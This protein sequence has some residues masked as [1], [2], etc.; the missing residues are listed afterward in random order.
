[1]PRATFLMR[2]FAPA[3]TIGKLARCVGMA[4]STL[5]KGFKCVFGETI[6]DFSLR[7]R[8]QH[9]MTMICEQRW[10]VA[11]ASEA[12]G[13][14]HPTSFTTAFRRHFGMRPMDVRRLKT[15]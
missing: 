10:S 1:M 13:Y 8:M 5:T 9:A 7:C 2:Q 11:K 15:R 3:P 12:V 14:A 4:E 6:F